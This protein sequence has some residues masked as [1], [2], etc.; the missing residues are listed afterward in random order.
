MQVEFEKPNKSIYTF[1][2][3]L[4]YDD[5]SCPLGPENLL[6]RSSVFCNTD[7]AY[8]V[9]LYTGRDSKIQMNNSLPPNKMS[10]FEKYANK[11]IAGVFVAQTLLVLAAVAS[12]YALGYDDFREKLPYVYPNGSTSTVIP[13]WLEQIIVFYI[14][15]NN[16]TDFPLRDHGALQSWAGRPGS[17]RY[18]NV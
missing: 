9:A 13:L 12:F 3:A 1:V 11:A 8:G 5:A 7:W 17:I 14:L 2:G 10:N 16:F 4:H 18:A 15:Y 6:L